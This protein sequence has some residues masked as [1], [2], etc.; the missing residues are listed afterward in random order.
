MSILL[1]KSSGASYKTTPEKGP[2][3]YH[4][5]S[6]QEITFCLQSQSFIPHDTKT[7]PLCPMALEP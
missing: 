1:H 6:P 7:L 5:R 4:P 3:L 2:I